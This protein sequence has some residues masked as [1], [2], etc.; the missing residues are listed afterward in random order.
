MGKKASIP[1]SGFLPEILSRTDI[2]KV[3]NSVYELMCEV[4]IRFDPDPR[5]LDLF[6][7]SG[8]DISSESVIKIH[9]DLVENSLDSVAKKTQLYDRNGSA[10]D[11]PGISF[12]AGMGCINI[13]DIETGERRPST[14]EDLAMVARVVDA[15][16]NIDGIC[17]PCKII[18]RSDVYG[19]IDEFNVI[20]SNTTKPFAY[21]SEY[22]ESLEAAI[23]LAAVIRG[24]HDQ[25]REK[26][27]FSYG[28]TQMPLYY[29]QKEIDQIFIGIENGIPLGSGSIIIGGATGPMTIAGSLVHCIAT[30]FALIVLGQLIEKGCYCVSNSEVNFMDPRNGN[31]GGI[32]EMHLGELARIQIF[33]KLGLSAGSG[34]GGSTSPVFNQ[35]CSAD[36]ASSMMHAFYSGADSTYYLGGIESGMT[37][38]LHCLLYGNE[39]A[40]MV[41]RMEKGIEINEDTLAMAVT[42]KV[43]L[44]CNYLAERHTVN[45]CRTELWN[46][47]YFQNLNVE[48]WV[49]EGKKD[50]FDR[51]DEDLKRILA[52]HQPEAIP[53]NVRQGMDEVL[54]KYGVI[55]E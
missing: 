27:Y 3:L 29:A 37:Y 24:G 40:G 19:E 4:G 31:F 20:A 47:G 7:A 45:H 46:P 12:A 2:E 41:R 34:A 48:Q 52:E 1:A 49:R 10:V 9:R 35:D 32:P 54:K 39:L 15:L 17:Q 13:V 36:V 5:V 22:V 16:P 23:E 6:S 28:I 44:K 51:I 38:S 14:R 30:D 11:I 33:H 42:K 50:L 53:D 25:L 26:P 18:E 21:I 43:G 8:C 55:E